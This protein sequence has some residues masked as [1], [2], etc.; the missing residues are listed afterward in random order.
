ME[1]VYESKQRLLGQQIQEI[2]KSEG[3]SDS[4]PF[5]TGW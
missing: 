1:D 2:V 3:Y 5:D 4:I